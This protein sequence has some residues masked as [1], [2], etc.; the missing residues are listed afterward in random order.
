MKN[1]PIVL[2]FLCTSLVWCSAPQAM[3]DGR[4][5]LDSKVGDDGRR[6]I[7]VLTPS[8]LEKAKSLEEFHNQQKE[9]ESFALLES[10][11]SAEKEEYQRDLNRALEE[12]EFAEAIRLSLEGQPSETN[13]SH[14]PLENKFQVLKPSDLSLP[15]VEQED[16]SQLR[17]ALLESTQEYEAHREKIAEQGRQAQERRNEAINELKEVREIREIQL[18]SLHSRKDELR[19]KETALKEKNL[20]DK[21]KL[22]EEELRELSNMINSLTTEI[23]AFNTLW[24]KIHEE[25]MHLIKGGD[26]RDLPWKQELFLTRQGGISS[27]PSSSLGSLP[28]IPPSALPNLNRDPSKDSGKNPGSGYT[29]L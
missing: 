28:S 16:D 5:V 27:L 13:S 18:R 26:P 10:I 22:V 3:E 14:D 21:S 1:T 12:S 19:S 25:I 4:L 15:I 17:K 20:T 11:K 6:K 8:G 24:R 7:L 23:E 29:F 9:R 2:T